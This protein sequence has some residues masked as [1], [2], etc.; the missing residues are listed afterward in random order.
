MLRLLLTDYP[1]IM[2]NLID[3]DL[4]GFVS[5]RQAPDATRKIINLIHYAEFTKTPTTFLTLDAKKAFDRIH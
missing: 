4:V 3:P 5:G 1:P 2:S